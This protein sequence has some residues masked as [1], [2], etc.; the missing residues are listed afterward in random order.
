MID[1]K[2]FDMSDEDDVKENKIY[3]KS[4]DYYYALWDINEYLYKNKTLSL[5]TLNN[6]LDE[7]EI[8]FY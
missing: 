1:I 8:K 3:S 7:H 5:K 6:I 4:R 2:I